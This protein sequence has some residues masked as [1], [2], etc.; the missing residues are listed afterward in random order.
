MSRQSLCPLCEEGHLQE[1]IG[2]TS[3]EYRGQKA[4]LDSCF[5]VCDAC[6]SETA[7]PA[8]VRTN[9]R[10]MM[11]FKKSV[12]GLLTGSEVR[13]LR[14]KW[15]I[16]QSRAA[17]LFGGGPVAFSKYESDDVMQSEAMDK[18]LRVAAALPEVVTALKQL[19]GLER[20]HASARW[21]VL[22]SQVI[23]QTGTRVSQAH[24]RL[25]TRRMLADPNDST[26]RQYA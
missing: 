20:A 13:A 26:V 18:L 15:G 3:V 9:K 16:T 6:G 7:T 14:E 4:L 11:A 1:H 8:Q 21:A 12:D 5:S 24:L 2:K 17:Q 10:T 22:E 23:A 19:S 25:V